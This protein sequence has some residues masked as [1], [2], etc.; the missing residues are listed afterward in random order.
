MGFKF[1]EHTADVV[2]EAWGETLERAFENAAR[3]TFEVMTDTSRVEPRVGREI[4]VEGFD[5][6]N[7]LLRWIEEL[8]LLFDSEN[9][10]LG[11]FKVERIAETQEGYRLNAT[12]RG[13]RF[14][15]EKHESRTH[16]KA[17][18]Y[19]QMKIWKENYTWRVRFTLDI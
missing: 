19:A 2:I 5:L 8:L 13:E 1:I 7:L 17:V 3:A 9:L 12:V 11:E 4:E 15:S 6:E 16:V 18:T 10:L 14:N